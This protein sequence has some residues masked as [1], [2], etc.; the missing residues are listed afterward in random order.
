[1]ATRRIVPGTGRALCEEARNLGKTR[2]YTGEPCSRGHIAERMV[3]NRACCI[4]LSDKRKAQIAAN[5]E[6]RRTSKANSRK[7]NLEQYQA[8]GRAN[9]AAN[10]EHRAA[11]MREYRA[12]N[13]DRIKATKKKTYAKTYDLILARNRKRRAAERNAPG[14]HAAQDIVDIRKLQRDRCAICEVPLHGGGQI[15]HVIP[16][17]KGGSDDRSNLQLACGPCNSRKRDKDPIDFMRERGLL[18]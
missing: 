12:A 1:M 9:Y 10:A 4:C 14:S 11:K 15:D 7:K 18:L 6:Q 2:F 17:A 8:T 16:L 3:S 5:P 13:P